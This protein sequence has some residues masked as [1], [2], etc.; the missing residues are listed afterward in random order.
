MAQKA[1]APAQFIGNLAIGLS[2]AVL[3]SPLA[4]SAPANAQVTRTRHPQSMEVVRPVR[5]PV[6]RPAQVIINR[7]SQ[8]PTQADNAG[9]CNGVNDCNNFIAICV[10]GGGTYVPGTTNG[11][12]QPTSGSCQVD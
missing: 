5:P 1:V 8:E 12:G 2:M 10:G 6:P 4:V 3:L 7:D 11:Q 9:S